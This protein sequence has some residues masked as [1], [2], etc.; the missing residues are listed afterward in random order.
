[1]NKL[2]Q[3]YF[4]QLCTHHIPLYP[5]SITFKIAN[6]VRYTPDI[7]C[8]AWP[9][10]GENMPVA[11]EIKGPWMTDDAVV[12]LKVFAN[13]YPHIKVLLASKNKETG[14]WFNQEV[15]G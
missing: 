12:K 14:L 13:A 2:E 10:R 15:W 8:F 7:F 3:E 1:M 9:W 5:Q 11:W 6:G 4:D